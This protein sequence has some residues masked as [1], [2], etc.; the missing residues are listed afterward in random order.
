MTAQPL[1]SA[2]TGTV[3]F[4]GVAGAG[5][6]SLAE[7]FLRSGLSVTGCDL[8]PREAAQALTPLGARV[9]SG[10]DPE[11]VEDISALVVTAAVPSDH[12]EIL[13]ARELG[14]PVLK[15]AEALGEWVAQGQVVGVAGTHGKTTTTAMATDV[16]ASAGL[17][18]TGLVG[19]R[20]AA[21]GSNLRFGG[22]R[23]FVVEADEY[24]RSFLHL[25]PQVAVVTNVEADHLDV[26]G[27]LEG[28]QEAFR[29]FLDGIPAEGHVAVCGDDHGASRLLPGLGGR[30]LTY[31][32]N[33]GAQLRAVGLREEKEGTR[34]SVVEEGDP[35]G[36]ITLRVPG[37]HNV[38]NALG[39][40]MAARFLGV[41]WE[42]I[43]RGLGEFQGVG[44]RFQ[45][46]GEVGG[47]LVV[48][49]YA[50]HPTE[51]E[52]TLAAARDRFPN[53][54]IVAVFQPHL[55]S[56][57]RDFAKEFGQALAGADEVWVADIYPAREQPIPGVDGTLVAQAAR[58]AGVEDV[59]FHGD[60]SDLAAEISQRLRSGDVCLT[61]G[62]GSIEF[63]GKEILAGLSE[64]R[65]ARGVD[66]GKGGGG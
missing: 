36:E 10:H 52:A 65:A 53:R 61:M 8:S 55:Y 9:L 41:G 17:D 2:T 13:R 19:G 4:M 59:E 12:P 7:L 43:S 57:T 46:L 6:I 44:R 47:V 31:G 60:L 34:F 24:D 18:P 35:Q 38:Q 33:P 14:V 49:D 27:D 62:A 28:V 29:I 40:A 42:A 30:A 20:V 56:R 39:A 45:A 54:R 1:S 37:R 5:M 16:M 21:W 48:D 23:L 15:R 3:H 22:G 64:S 26:Y 50:H 51:I 58:D 32:L 25:K 66:S 11:H 63:L